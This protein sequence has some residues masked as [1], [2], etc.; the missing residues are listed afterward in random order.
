MR[1]GQKRFLPQVGVLAKLLL[2]MPATNA[3]SER[4]FSVETR[5]DVSSSNNN[6]SAFKLFDVAAHPQ[7]K[8]YS[9]NLID[10]VNK[11]AWKEN[12]REIF[13]MFNEN[14]VKPKAEYRNKSSQTKLRFCIRT[15]YFLNVPI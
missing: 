5:Q 10:V 9:L 15:H 1:Q 6:K 7:R 8:T 13:R 12:R 4:S 11:F 14:D 3:V 2:V